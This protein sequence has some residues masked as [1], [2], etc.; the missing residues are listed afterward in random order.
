MKPTVVALAVVHAGCDL[1]SRTG[2][3]DCF[4]DSKSHWFNESILLESNHS[5]IETE[6]KALAAAYTGRVDLLSRPR[7]EIETQSYFA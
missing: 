6:R 3:K 5:G 1:L 4:I 2:Y 7:G